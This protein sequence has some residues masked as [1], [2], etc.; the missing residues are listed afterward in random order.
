[1]VVATARLLW[2]AAAE[3][4]PPRWQLM[5]RNP[6]GLPKDLGRPARTVLV[7]DS[8][9]PETS[10]SPIGIPL[11]GQGIDVCP[12][13]EVGK[14]GR[15]K[16]GHLAG[17]RQCGLRRGDGGQR[18]RIMQGGQFGPAGDAPLY[19][20]VDQQALRKIG[21]AVDHTVPYDLNFRQVLSAAGMSFRQRSQRTAH[22][23]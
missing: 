8:V 18:R 23:R 22:G 13:G 16:D 7:A 3:Q 20:A 11:I 14:E 5:I 1:M 15:I 4:P 19:H 9:K 2:M 6:A 12:G 10:H 21:P 17:V